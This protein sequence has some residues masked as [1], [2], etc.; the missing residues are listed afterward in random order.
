MKLPLLG[1]S[2]FLSL[3]LAGCVGSGPVITETVAEPMAISLLIPSNGAPAP[4]SPD[5]LANMLQSWN[6]RTTTPVRTPNNSIIATNYDSLT[7]KLTADRFTVR[8]AHGMVYQSMNRDLPGEFVQ[9]DGSLQMQVTDSAYRLVLTP[10]KR[11]EAPYFDKLT[12]KESPR[13]FSF[14]TKEIAADLATLQLPWKL[15]FDSPFGSD[16][17]YAN[18]ARLARKEVFRGGERDAV[19]GKIFKER[20]WI[21]VSG[22][23]VPLL[24]ETYPYRAG[25]K[26][27][28]HAL[29]TGQLNGAVI[30]FVAAIE[31]L[32][33]EAEK[34]VK[35]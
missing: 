1:L 17:T 8:R 25:S 23:D 14:T 34:I 29:I 21:R 28:V 13:T 18:F 6:S 19:T 11:S 5:L 15:E 31:A 9:Y 33:K 4:T 16:A 26:V 20:F 12:G 27:V 24:I 35:S 30:D 22:R 3:S 7:W 2:A 10:Q 32:R